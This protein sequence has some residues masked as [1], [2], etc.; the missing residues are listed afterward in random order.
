MDTLTWFYFAIA[1]LGLALT[2][3]PNS[4]LVMTHSVRFGPALTFYTI[5][6]GIFTFVLLM[7]ISM[8]GIDALLQAYP[9]LLEYIKI[10]GGIYIVWLGLKQF[11]LTRL[12]P[13]EDARFMYPIN[14]IS[15]F[16]QGA[17]SAGSNPKVFLFFG[18]FLTQFIDPQRDIVLQLI[19]MAITFSVAEFLVELLISISAAKCRKFLVSNGKAFNVFCGAI[20]V[21]IG[22]SVLLTN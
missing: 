6:G 21:L 10:V 20:F 11:L 5:S 12:T 15:L 19:V 1:C 8:F 16:T 7:I 3:G 18:A 13:S 9:P 14:R 4:L 2:P 22:A 17:A